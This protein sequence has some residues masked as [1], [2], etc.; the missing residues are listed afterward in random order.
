MASAARIQARLDAALAR[1]G[2]AE[3]W[4]RF[5]RLLGDV[6]FVL[7]FLHALQADWNARA[8]EAG[9]RLRWVALGRRSGASLFAEADPAFISE[10][11]LDEVAGKLEPLAL[12]RRWRRGPR[13]VAVLT[14]AQSARLATAAWLGGVPLRAGVADNGLRPLYHAA[15]PYRGLQDHLAA[16]L[17]GLSRALGVPAPFHRTLGPDLLGGRSVFATLAAA[18]WDGQ[19]S[20]VAL[21]PGTRAE[22]K[23]WHPELPHWPDLAERL[24]AAGLTPVVLGLEEETPL[25]KAIQTRVPG[26]LD[27]TGRTSLP[28]AAALLHRAGAAVAVDTGLAHL[29]AATGCA[30][31]TLFGPSHEWFAQPIG[32]WSQGLRGPGTAL[33]PSDARSAGPHQ[34]PSLIRLA[35]ERVARV[36]LALR[37]ERASVLGA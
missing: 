13:P 11:R 5:P 35:P 33:D 3:V 22:G 14:L 25:A 4:I 8:A 19:T 31:V 30:T 12:A 18:G 9:A 27:L 28:E 10:L 34:E 21:A 20:L 26:A 15:V 7:P 2:E 6:L 32:P 37:E 23:R 36:L 16:R 24:A 29:A 17:G 1:G